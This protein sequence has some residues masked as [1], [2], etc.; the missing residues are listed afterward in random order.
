MKQLVLFFSVLFLM[1]CSE[2]EEKK[3][4]GFLS[5]EEA[6]GAHKGWEDINAGVISADGAFYSED[7]LFMVE[8]PGTPEH[9]SKLVETELGKVQTNSYIYSPSIT[10]GYM[11]FYSDY[12]TEYVRKMDKRSMLLNAMEGALKPIG[13]DGTERMEEFQLN[14]NPAV[15]F[16]GQ[17]EHMH[18]AGRLYLIE[19]RLYQVSIIRDGSYPSTEAIDKFFDSFYIVDVKL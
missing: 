11:V 1:A 13:I 6:L 14:G 19:N 10:E 4:E 2:A 15:E 7:G 16:M 17:G 9:T 5:E 8:F 18:I 12:P 3:G